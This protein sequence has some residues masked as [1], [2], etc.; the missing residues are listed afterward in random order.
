[1]ASLRDAGLLREAIVEHDLRKMSKLEWASFPA[2]LEGLPYEEA[3]QILPTM[4]RF[5]G[6]KSAII[7]PLSAGGRFIS[8]A[9][10]IAI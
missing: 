2:C 8:G 3:K 7:V 1:M 4:G 10:R 6:W 5:G 9:E